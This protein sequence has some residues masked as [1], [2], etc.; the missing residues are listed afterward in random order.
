MIMLLLTCGINF[1]F[2]KLMMNSCKI[3]FI[4]LPEKINNKW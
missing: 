4:A 1:K 2:D 3:S